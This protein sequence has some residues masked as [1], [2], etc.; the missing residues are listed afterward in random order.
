MNI[1]LKIVIGAI[2]GAAAGWGMYRMVGCSSGACPMT[3]H[4]YLTPI[5]WGLMGA[6]LAAGSH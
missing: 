5:L 2:A 4:R 3:G 1:A 6:M